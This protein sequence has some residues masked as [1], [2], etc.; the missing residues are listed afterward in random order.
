MLN[1]V[2]LEAKCVNCNKKFFPRYDLAAD[3]YWT[4]TIGVTSLNCN[5]KTLEK[6]NFK[7][8][9]KYRKTGPRYNCP[10]C[11]ND[12]Y[13]KC[14]K[15]GKLTCYESETKKF[16]CAHCGNSGEVSGSISISDYK[17]LVKSKGSG[18]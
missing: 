5:Q 8:Q 12:S 16:L 15:C 4:L 2:F 18:Q 17:E 9:P 7:W 13:V 6:S 1:T 11:G 3:G 10:W 14:G